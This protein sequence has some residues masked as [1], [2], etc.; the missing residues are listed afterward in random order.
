VQIAT[1]SQLCRMVCLSKQTACVK[2]G[3]PSDAK[4]PRG[5]NAPSRISEGLWVSSGGHLE[6]GTH[7]CTMVA[8]CGSFWFVELP[9]TGRQRAFNS[10]RDQE[11][12]GDG[13]QHVFHCVPKFSKGLGRGQFGLLLVPGRPLALPGSP[14]D[15]EISKK[16]TSS[17]K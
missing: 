11:A 17:T 8:P 16:L 6:N 2:R 4:G 10:F 13:S 3:S 15:L 9:E 5:R 7:W 1:T 14:P 12:S